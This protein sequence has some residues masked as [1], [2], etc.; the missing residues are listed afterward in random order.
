MRPLAAAFQGA[1]EIG[2][3]V[4][5][6]TLTLAAVYAPV[7]F[8]PGRTGRLFLEFA[9]TLAGAVLVSGFVALTL[10]P[11]M[12]SK[13]LRRD[14]R[15]NVFGRIVE[16]AVGGLQRGYHAI[17]AAGAA[18]PHRCPGAGA[19]RRR[20]GRLDV[21]PAQVRAFADRGPRNGGGDRQRAR[22]RELRLHPALCRR[23]RRDPRPGSRASVL[24]GDRRLGAGHPVQFLCPPEGLE[25]AEGEPAGR[26]AAHPAET[27]QDRRRPGVAPPTPPR[28]AC[29]ARASP[30]SS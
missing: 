22:G 19:R 14:G 3:A 23:D 7:A 11:M 10:T 27:A 30:S 17:V 26:R 13:L 18:G 12:C 2:F 8:T 24:S 29:A 21:F 20:G 16:G 15:A 6:M 4:I 28:S 9:L 1:R 25:R 5:A